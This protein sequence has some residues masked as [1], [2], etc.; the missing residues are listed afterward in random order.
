MTD[1]IF[2]KIIRKEIPANLLYEDEQ[3]I[4]IRDINPVAPVHILLIPKKT[5]P[6]AN[7][8]SFADASAVGHLFTVAARLAEQEGIAADG[9]RL[10]IN[11]GENGQQTVQ[12]LHLHL[13]GGRE[14]SWPPG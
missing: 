9:Y 5:I 13:I 10:V 12:Q 3:A 2:H 4:A 7:S 1:T 11:C 14:F 6:D 8:I